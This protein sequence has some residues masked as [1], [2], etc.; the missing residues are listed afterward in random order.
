MCVC[1]HF[2]IYGYFGPILYGCESQWRCPLKYTS[3]LPG[4]LASSPGCGLLSAV[5][6]QAARLWLGVLIPRCDAEICDSRVGPCDTLP[7][8]PTPPYLMITYT[9]R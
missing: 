1:T 6:G 5:V 4:S 8:P 2:K 3:W 7:S 9:G